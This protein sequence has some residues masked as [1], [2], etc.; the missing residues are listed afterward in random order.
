MRES[1]LQHGTGHAPKHTSARD[2]RSRH[3]RAELENCSTSKRLDKAVNVKRL[4]WHRRTRALATVAAKSKDTT[5][6]RTK[7]RV[8]RMYRKESKNEEI[9][10][11]LINNRAVNGQGVH[12]N[13]LKSKE[14]ATA[15]RSEREQGS[16]DGKIT[17]QQ[18]ERKGAVAQ[19]AKKEGA[20][21]AREE[22]PEATQK[23]KARNINMK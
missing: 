20:E 18:G 1:L 13:A 9:I 7:P 16:N 17:T 4:A 10:I 3:K 12:E 2:Q 5:S 19:K 11:S 15:E 14:G 22:R 21:E 6:L 8:E 23:R